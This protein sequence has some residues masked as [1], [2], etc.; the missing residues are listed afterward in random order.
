M[1]DFH[2]KKNPPKNNPDIH[3]LTD[4]TLKRLSDEF[5]KAAGKVDLSILPGD[6]SDEAYRGLTNRMHEN[7]QLGIENEELKEVKM[8]RIMRLVG[9][10]I[11]LFMFVASLVFIWWFAARELNATQT[12]DWRVSSAIA[13]EPIANVLGIV[14]VFV[15]Y[16]YP[17]KR[18]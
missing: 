1:R 14:L 16:I 10:F 11:C 5:S 13:T 2:K 17:T 18:K 7:I 6:K 15:R 9:G 8:G 3:S 12:L 4:K